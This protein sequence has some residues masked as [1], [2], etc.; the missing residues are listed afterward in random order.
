MSGSLDERFTPEQELWLRENFA[1]Y[2]TYRALTGA[3]NARFSQA[4][5]AG[6]LSDKCGKRMGL[7]RDGNAGRFGSG[8]KKDGLPVGA[9]RRSRTGTYIKMGDFAQ[10]I[11]GYQR[12]NWL[13]LQEK[14]WRDA[15][16]P[17]PDGVMICFLDGNPQNFALDNLYP[18]TRAQSVRMAQRGWWSDCAQV[19]KTGILCCQLEEGI[20]R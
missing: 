1:Q 20:E 19:T 2:P 13:P 6:S 10:G 12:P 4:R 14:I 17:L 11:S 16:G 7:R 18:V 8:R 15:H 9:I 3:F 5:A